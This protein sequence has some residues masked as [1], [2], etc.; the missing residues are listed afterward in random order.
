MDLLE[1][2]LKEA[3]VITGIESLSSSLAGR[4][5]DV[6]QA[7]DNYND[8]VEKWRKQ[9]G[10]ED[11]EKT[12]MPKFSS[13]YPQRKKELINFACTLAV[14]FAFKVYEKQCILQYWADHKD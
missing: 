9:D 14:C 8:A 5:K 4:N 2:S 12:P 6:E 11:K 10:L 1:S 3:L 13:F 7:F